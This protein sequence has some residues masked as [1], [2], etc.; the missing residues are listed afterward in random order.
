MSHDNL[1]DMCP[2]LPLWWFQ[3]EVSY[4]MPVALHHVVSLRGTLPESDRPDNSAAAALSSSW[5]LGVAVVLAGSI[6]SKK[7]LW[8]ISPDLADILAEADYAAQ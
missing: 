7:I 3:V 8:V 5:L 4:G 1:T 6:V 2:A